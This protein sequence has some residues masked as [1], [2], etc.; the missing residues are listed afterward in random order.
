MQPIKKLLFLSLFLFFNFVQIF[1]MG[2][3]LIRP[4]HIEEDVQRLQASTTIPQCIIQSFEGRISSTPLYEF[5][6]PSLDGVRCGAYNDTHIAIGTNKNALT[7]N[8]K[9][10]PV[11]RRFSSNEPI[12]AIAYHAAKQR[13]AI[14]YT[15][16]LQI[17]DISSRSKKLIFAMQDPND[18]EIYACAF[19]DQGDQIAFGST[20]AYIYDIKT[21]KLVQAFPYDWETN[22]VRFNKLANLLIAATRYHVHVLNIQTGGKLRGFEHDKEVVDAALNDQETL[23]TTV[24]RDSKVR[25]FN[26]K[27]QELLYVPEHTNRGILN[28]N[29]TRLLIP[30]DDKIR[31]LETHHDF[32]LYTPIQ[33]QILYLLRKQQQERRPIAIEKYPILQK[34]IAESPE[35]IQQEMLRSASHPEGDAMRTILGYVSEKNP[36]NS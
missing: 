7:L 27:T 29:G 34:L 21:K 24:C 1:A 18:E 25:I 23:L 36:T 33:Y 5:P 26:F 6:N 30:W 31:I 16:L 8:A 2:N 15:N 10:G 19:N 9:T 22:S 11:L 17:F 14:A 3:Q 12:N 35:R 20:G 32:S 4:D 28:S 13:L